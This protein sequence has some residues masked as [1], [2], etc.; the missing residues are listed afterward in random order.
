MKSNVLKRLGV[1]EAQRAAVLHATQ[2]KY[3]SVKTEEWFT[4]VFRLFGTEP[5]P[6]ESRMDALARCVEMGSWELRQLL[7][8]PDEFKRVV[9]NALERVQQSRAAA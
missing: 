3:D 9:L 8:T 2:S 1:L 4:G 5:G 6:N 7:F